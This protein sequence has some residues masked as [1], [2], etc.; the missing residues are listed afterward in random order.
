MTD[1]EQMIVEQLAAI[2][3][4]LEHLLIPVARQ[5]GRQVA[6]DMTPAE[7]RA[8]NKAVR[9]RAKKKAGITR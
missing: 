1:F 9:E 8:H 5:E 6:A 4:K 3:A 2:N 7:T